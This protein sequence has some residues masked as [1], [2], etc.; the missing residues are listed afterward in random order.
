MQFFW[1]LAYFV[2]ALPTGWYARRFGYRAGI[3]TGLGLV[4]LG[5][6]IV[7]PACRV[8]T[9]AAF[10][11]ILF[12]IAIGLTFLET[13][14][15]PYA[16][17]LGPAEHGVARIN[18][19]Q[20]CNAIGWILGP[21]VVGWF[22]LSGTARANTSNAALYL[23]Y[24]VV[25]ALARALA[26]SFC[27]VPVPEIQP[28]AEEQTAAGRR[29]HPRPLFGSGISR[30]PSPRSFCIAPGRRASSASSSISSRTICR[31]FPPGLWRAC[32]RA[33]VMPGTTSG[34]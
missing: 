9:Y 30:W 1:Y 15:N 11:A 7:Y 14:A 10:L 4:V 23:P 27:V 20:S 5:A 26:C 18:F 2:L 8:N 13:I 21:S 16:T 12:L 31:P 19:A 28:P 22:V 3:V 34:T 32:R 17:V 6:L 24:L 25:A 33:C 29:R